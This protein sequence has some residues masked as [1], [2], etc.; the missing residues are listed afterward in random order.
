MPRCDSQPLLQ[1]PSVAVA[2]LQHLKDQGV[3]LAINHS[4]V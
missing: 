3:Q 4:P 2:T 1:E